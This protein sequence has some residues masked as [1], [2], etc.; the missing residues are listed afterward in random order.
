MLRS[1]YIFFVAAF[2]IIF[3]TATPSWAGT[4]DRVRFEFKPKVVS[5]IIDR[6]EG[7]TKFLVAS[8]CAFEINATGIIGQISV[9]FQET[10]FISG[11]DFGSA[12][13]L[14]GKI[15][16]TTFVTNHYASPIYTAERR[17]ARHPGRP[18]DQA[19]LVSITYSNATHPTFIFEPKAIQS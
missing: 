1:L 11:T 19:V 18:I 13:Q 9:E 17:T 14:P 5:Q 8:N 7:N 2:L 15:D 12:A 16:Q 10:G 3:G 4:T 6:V